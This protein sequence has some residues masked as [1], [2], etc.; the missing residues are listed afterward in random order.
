LFF[1]TRPYSAFFEQNTHVDVHYILL[2]LSTSGELEVRVALTLV[3][4]AL[5][6]RLFLPLLHL[7]PSLDFAFS[8]LNQST[9]TCSPPPL[10]SPLAYLTT[11]VLRTP[12]SS[13]SASPT[14]S[15]SLS[16][17]TTPKPARQRRNSGS[18]TTTPRAISEDAFR[19]CEGEGD[20]AARGETV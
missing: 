17:T 1:N 20:E 5:L 13:P 18:A 19:R 16:S 12:T 8:D 6:Y 2:L 3:V 11:P 15:S 7:C 4:D 10:S 14:L 9:P